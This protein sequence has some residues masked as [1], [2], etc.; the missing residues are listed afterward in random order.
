[1]FPAAMVLSATVPRRSAEQVVC[2]GF[3]SFN[4]LKSPATNP[5]WF[6]VALRIGATNGFAGAAHHPHLSLAQRTQHPLIKDYT[7]N[8]TRVPNMM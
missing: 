2:R 5:T 7:L 1:M 3:H 4:E 8:G 6:Q